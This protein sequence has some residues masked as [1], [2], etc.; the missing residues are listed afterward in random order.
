MASN[1]VSFA[2]YPTYIYLSLIDL[3]SIVCLHCPHCNRRQERPST[4]NCLSVEVPD[5]SETQ[6]STSISTVTSLLHNILAE[7][8]LD[9]DNKWKCSSCGEAV[10][11]TRFTTLQSLP[12]HLVIQ[13][14]RFAYD[15]KTMHRVKLMTPVSF[16]I[17]TNFDSLLVRDLE[18]KDADRVPSQYTLSGVVYHLGTA[19][20]GHYKALVRS[21]STGQWFDCDDDR[22]TLMD[23][24]TVQILLQSNRK[25][26]E[27]A[28]ASIPFTE[29]SALLLKNAYLL[30]YSINTYASDE[31]SIPSLAALPTALQIHVQDHNDN[32]QKLWR[33]QSIRQNVCQC[34]I[35]IA[36]SNNY[37]NDSDTC[38]R[39]NGEQFTVFIPHAWTLGRMKEYLFAQNATLR[40][41]L[42]TQPV[43][44]DHNRSRLRKSSNL[45]LT[46]S[47]SNRGRRCEAETFGGR[48]ELTL[49]ALRFTSQETLSLDLRLDDLHDPSFSEFHPDDFFV[50]IQCWFE[51]DLDSSN[52]RDGFD[53]QNGWI[54]LPIPGRT[55]VT[56]KDLCDNIA[57]YLSR[58][59]GNRQFQ[60]ITYPWT[61]HKQCTLFFP[62]PSADIS[63]TELLRSLQP[64]GVSAGDR[65]VV[66]VGYPTNDAPSSNILSK[67]QH[68]RSR[69][70]LFCN[71]PRSQPLSHSDQSLYSHRIEASSQ[72][73]LLQ[74]HQHLRQHWQLSI[75]EP[76]H[77][78]RS[79]TGRQWKIEGED[80]IEGPEDKSDLKEKLDPKEASS[81][82][83]VARTI[84][85]TR[86]KKKRADTL[87]ELGLADQSIVHIQLG[88]GCAPGQHRVRLE[89]LQLPSH[90][91]ATSVTATTEDSK[92]DNTQIM[93][94]AND[95][96][97]TANKSDVPPSVPAAAAAGLQVLGDVVV[98]EQWT[99]L[100]LKK[101]I[102]SRWSTWS[103][104]PSTVPASPHHIRLRDLKSSHSSI[105]SSSSTS[106]SISS[107]LQQSAVLRDDRVLAR[108]MLGL[109]DGRRLAVQVLNAPEILRADDLLLRVRVASYDHKILHIADDV[110]VPRTCSLDEL[111]RRILQ[112]F[113]DLMEVGD[114]TENGAELPQLLDI[115]KA[116]ST[117]P[118]LTLKTALKLKWNDGLVW[119]SSQSTDTSATESS[120]T[121]TTAQMTIDRPPWSLRDGSLLVVRSRRDWAR[122]QA[123]VQAKKQQQESLHGTETDSVAS[124]SL[125]AAGNGVSAVRA[126]KASS[127]ATGSTGRGRGGV[128][129][130]GRSYLRSGGAYAGF[131][132]SGS[133][134]SRRVEHS[135]KIVP[136]SS[137]ASSSIQTSS[138]SM[139]PSVGA[140]T[141]LH[142]VSDT[143]F[144][145]VEC[146][147]DKIEDG[148]DMIPPLPITTH[149]L[150]SID[151]INADDE[152]R[153][154]PSPFKQ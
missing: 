133:M 119:P 149:T 12:S 20:G 18:G 94:G 70:E 43:V 122:A 131:G 39:S 34:S 138:S 95:D 54:S 22:I 99:V 130:S 126:V 56:V 116:F 1:T 147:R 90:R 27:E 14:K 52:R 139:D 55:E 51:T 40:A 120:L 144:V 114:E 61:A 59:E 30:F 62:L 23:A 36:T 60:L 96:T 83:I 6:S 41:L 80:D 103:I 50:E 125:E 86:A 3:F 118:P 88:E 26:E 46:S 100:Q 17:E 75:D 128:S 69:I 129:S 65:L 63:E 79:A 2:T 13:L 112:H 127:G 7:E 19:M 154:P 10:C 150:P 73:T 143:E 11:A 37:S 68:L 72:W 28:H 111:Q 87:Q 15:K 97:T 110:C 35:T 47:S 57:R 45:S 92:E 24:A 49:Q 115:A 91:P 8:V 44:I 107:L 105:A 25:G 113:P 38:I 117:G 109:S 89:M 81:T 16:P 85:I 48:E 84:S 134:A 141:P 42:E 29:K 153:L 136:A 74:L 33:V 5:I 142:A 106:S 135:L 21:S 102:H 64:H 151:D 123:R 66:R 31:I 148:T 101:L 82:V 77:L 137:G 76:F 58:D 53:P 32:F 4:F 121:T 93:E 9:E 71:D 132:G 146:G 108:C 67:L 98:A 124:T 78:R 140:E 104:P 145:S 152:K